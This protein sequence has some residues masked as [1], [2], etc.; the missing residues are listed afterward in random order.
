MSIPLNDIFHEIELT[1]MLE[2]RASLLRIVL[3]I[4]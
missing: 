2:L 3:V 4:K 1:F